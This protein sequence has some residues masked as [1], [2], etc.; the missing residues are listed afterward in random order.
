MDVPEERE[1]TESGTKRQATLMTKEGQKR[2]TFSVDKCGEAAARSMAIT[3]RQ[4]CLMDLRVK[5]LAFARHAEAVTSQYFA[6]NLAP[7][8]SALP[9]RATQ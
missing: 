7:A 5:H 3:R 4:R 8:E 9:H 6:S 2:R 1:E